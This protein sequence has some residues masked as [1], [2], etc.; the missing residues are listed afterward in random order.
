MTTRR[1]RIADDILL[2]ADAG[3][4]E[5]ENA[6]LRAALAQIAGPAGDPYDTWEA[7]V[8]LQALAGPEQER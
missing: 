4:L 5:A 2:P 6:R 8:A 7:R 1:P 3:D